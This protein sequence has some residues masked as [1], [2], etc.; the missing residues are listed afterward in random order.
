MRDKMQQFDEISQKWDEI[1][2]KLEAKKGMLYNNDKVVRIKKAIKDLK[3]EVW[4]I[5]ERIGV[6]Q[7]IIPYKEQEKETKHHLYDIDDFEI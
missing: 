1:N 5:D 4:R 2:E 6:I 3:L 7:A